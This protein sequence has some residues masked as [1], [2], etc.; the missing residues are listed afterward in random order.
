M[1]NETPF[2]SKRGRR[3]FSAS[4]NSNATNFAPMEG[5]PYISSSTT[6]SF[7]TL[8]ISTLGLWLAPAPILRRTMRREVRACSEQKKS[9]GFDTGAKNNHHTKFNGSKHSAQDYIEQF[10]GFARQHGFEPS[11]RGH[12]R[13]RSSSVLGPMMLARM[14]LHLDGVPNGWVHDWR[15]GKPARLEGERPE[16]STAEDRRRAV[17]TEIK[18]AKA[19]REDG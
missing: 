2:K 1:P 8:L 17:T 14:S 10:R 7:M 3:I 9:P 12:C 16:S 19:E 4:V 13:W 5:V 6:A 11:G 15:T 18:A